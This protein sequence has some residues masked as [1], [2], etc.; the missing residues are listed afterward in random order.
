LIETITNDS[1]KL[2]EDLKEII[3]IVINE[4]TIRGQIGSTNPTGPTEFPVPKPV[5]AHTTSLALSTT[6]VLGLLAGSLL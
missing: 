6:L 3:P 1:D 2:E 4:G 5:V